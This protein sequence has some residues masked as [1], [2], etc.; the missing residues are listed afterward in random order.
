MIP[1]VFQIFKFRI[2]LFKIFK[3][4]FLVLEGR[5]DFMIPGDLHHVVA[6]SAGTDGLFTNRNSLVHS[7][8]FALA[9]FLPM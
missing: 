8:K 6:M 4:F 1:R 7:I 9:T 3:E 5:F 2:K